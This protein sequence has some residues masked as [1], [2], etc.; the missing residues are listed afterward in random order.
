MSRVSVRHF[1]C[2]SSL[3]V[4]YMRNA[5]PDIYLDFL[6]TAAESERITVRWLMSGTHLGDF[7]QLPATCKAFAIEGM[8]LTISSETVG[9]VDTGKLLTSEVFYHKLAGLPYH[10]SNYFCKTAFI[11]SDY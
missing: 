7:P 11:V 1:K 3:R 2:E 9:S 8:I 4:A 10:P 5:F 6:E